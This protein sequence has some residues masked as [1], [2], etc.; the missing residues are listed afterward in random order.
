MRASLMLFF[1]YLFFV[2][3]LNSDPNTTNEKMFCC[4]VSHFTSVLQEGPQYVLCYMVN[5]E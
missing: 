3:R 5:T 2:D 4:L 1:N